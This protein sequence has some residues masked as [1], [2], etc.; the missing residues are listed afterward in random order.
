MSGI[1]LIKCAMYNILCKNKV[2]LGVLLCDDCQ[3][4]EE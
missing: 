2:M 3:G 1:I 4:E